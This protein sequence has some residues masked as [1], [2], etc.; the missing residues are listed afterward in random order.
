[1]AA[2]S[3]NRGI[4]YRPLFVIVRFE[5]LWT[6]NIAYARF[7]TKCLKTFTSKIPGMPKNDYQPAYLNNGGYEARLISV[8]IEDSFNTP[9]LEGCYPDW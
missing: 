9:A 5:A 8:S 7:V 3:S 4:Y 1:M 6:V 2:R